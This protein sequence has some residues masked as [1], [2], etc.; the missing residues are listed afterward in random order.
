MTTL[1]NTFPIKPAFM[2]DT[3]TQTVFIP[4]PSVGLLGFTGPESMKFLQG[5]TTTDFRE[6]AMGRVM[7]GSVCSLKGRVLYSYIAIPNGDDVQLLLPDDQLE[8]AF[9]HLKKYAVF[10]KTQLHDQRATHALMGVLGP[11][12]EQ[13]V[14]HLFGAAPAPDQVIHSVDG[15]WVCRM[16][17]E[18][19]FLLVFPAEALMIH[20][21][22]LSTRCIAEESVWWLAEIHAGQATIFAATR[23]IF[24]PQELNFHA[25]GAV[26][27]QKGCYV[28][29][30]VVARLY[31]RGKL[32]QRLYRLAGN[33][34]DALPGSAIFSEG[35]VVGHEV[36]SCTQNGV[37][38][39]LAVV[40]NAA[41][42]M[43]RV[44]HDE[45]SPA[46]PLAVSPSAL[47]R[48]RLSYGENGP[49]LTDLPLPYALPADEE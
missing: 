31:F 12:A 37:L 39:M 20:W 45:N 27:Y 15:R 3:A 41:M 13:E 18:S 14:A 5:Q 29:Q 21:N 23:D 34:Q 32:K 10:S 48:S 38:E 43:H 17:Q 35:Q 2:R 9:I 25:T 40:K 11:E 16:G 22:D 8:S 24:Q 33:A 36:M 28:G 1:W 30:E 26:S 6:V 19:R 49:T 7:R 47:W 4:L 44:S 46:P 42:Q